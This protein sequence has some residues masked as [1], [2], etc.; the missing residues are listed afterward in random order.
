MLDHI[1]LVMAEKTN[2]FINDKSFRESFNQV[3]IDIGADTYTASTISKAIRKLRELT[4]LDKM[5]NYRGAYKVNPLYFVKG[6]ELSERN[7]HRDKLVREYMEQIRKEKL[8]NR[9]N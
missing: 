3:F 2:V 1:T 9:G 6:S 7:T 5:P 4:I 8:F